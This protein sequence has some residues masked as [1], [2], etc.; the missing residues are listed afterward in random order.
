M[1]ILIVEDDQ[2]T[3]QFYLTIARSCG[4]APVAF[5]D[6]ESA[7]ESCQ[8]E[9]YSIA[10]LD[11]V[12]PGMDGLTLCKKYRELPN[13][14]QCVIL[15]STIRNS[16]EDFQAVLAA[17]ADDYIAKPVTANLL[18]IRLEIARRN[19]LKITESVRNDQQKEEILH[20][21]KLISLG[22]MVSGIA[23]ELNNPL[24][25]ILGLAQLL[26][27]ETKDE[28]EKEDLEDIVSLTLHCKSIVSDLLHFSQHENKEFELIDI[29][30]LIERFLH[31]WNGKLHTENISV[32]KKFNATSA[33]IQGNSIQL[34]QVFFN[35]YQN[36]VQAMPG[37]GKLRI[38]TEYIYPSKSKDNLGQKFIQIKFIDTGH[39]IAPQTLNHVFDPFFTTKEVG[40]G[41]G[42]GLSV[43]HGLIKK[44]GGN[45]FVESDGEGKGTRVT[46][47]L[48]SVDKG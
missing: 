21:E 41:I 4:L 37:G 36:A 22:I 47:H 10:I 31:L 29:N 34:S 45:I 9:S 40:T 1:K 8:K 30:E 12:L 19:V 32:E 18:K 43:C 26:S 46:I 6:A 20:A 24:Q 27:N 14:S 13:G 23:H 38:E 28:R 7:W 11:W 44:N 39:G 3:R 25:G 17:G 33:Q 16:E 15:V 42:L 35:L 2:V 5:P 48:P